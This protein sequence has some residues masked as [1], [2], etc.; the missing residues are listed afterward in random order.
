MQLVT[1]SIAPKVPRLGVLHYL[2]RVWKLQTNRYTV[3]RPSI[4]DTFFRRHSSEY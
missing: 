2:G 4:A 3:A 1:A